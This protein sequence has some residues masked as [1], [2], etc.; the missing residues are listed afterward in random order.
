MFYLF[1]SI[2]GIL[3]TIFFVIGFHEF[4]HFVAARLLN[5][6][7]E[8]FSIGFGKAIFR[9]HDKKGT[10]YVLAWLPL[11]GYVKMVDENEGNVDPKD[12]PR[13][14][15][16]Q[17]FLK[18]FLIVLAGP[19]TNI[20]SALIL[21]WL[22]F[23]IGFITIKPVIGQVTPQS[24]AAKAGLKSKDEIVAVDQHT[25]FTW[26]GIL[27]RIIVHAGDEDNLYINVM[28]PSTK[29][30][31]T[32]TLN[33]ATWSMNQL[34]P[35]PIGSLGI[36]P[37]AP[38][39]QMTIGVIESKSAAAKSGLQIGDKL[40]SVNNISLKQW[41]DL[42]KIIDENPQKTLL[43]TIERQGKQL[44][45]PVTIGHQWTFFLK[46]EGYLGIAPKVIWPEHLLYKI[47]YSSFEAFLKA[48]EEVKNFTYFNFVLLGKL[49]VGKVSLQSLGGPITLFENAGE[50]LNYGFL[51]F[52]SFLA[53]INISIGII[54][55]LPIPGLD[56]S[57]LL[58]QSIEAILRKPLHPTFLAIL[59]RIG[60]VFI[61]FIM[62]QAFINDILR[63]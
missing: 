18:K 48:C 10:E 60:F 32:Y 14:F 56:G 55:L 22:I 58:I 47:H 51:S 40:I 19:A 33:L 8:R 45:L 46:K 17:S 20:V 31:E 6:K 24:I 38:D 26:P 50:A 61:L 35:D 5:V 63:L 29:K 2:I 4:A 37:Y 1:I 27:F 54:N 52:M 15:N 34:T 39:I 44:K 59:Y 36:T 53:F 57:H 62:I 21:Y 13:A 25:V 11:G 12:L 43:F 49:V 9:W 41:K 16:R 30:T 28:R 3:L 7:V 42:V 23:M